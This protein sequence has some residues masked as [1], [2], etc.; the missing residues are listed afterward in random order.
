M[1]IQ[2]YNCGLTNLCGFHSMWQRHAGPRS[3]TESARKENRTGYFFSFTHLCLNQN[4]GR[5]VDDNFSIKS[6][7]LQTMQCVNDHIPDEIARFFHIVPWRCHQMETFS[8]LLAFVWGIHRSPVNS[9]HKGQWRGALMF[10]LICVWINGWVHNAEAGDL[11]H[12]RT[13]YDVLWCANLIGLIVI[14]HV[15]LGPWIT[16]IDDDIVLWRIYVSRWQCHKS[17]TPPSPGRRKQY[18]EDGR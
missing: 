3:M 17:V 13:H 9:P 5:P 12:S 14:S 10:S 2:A 6:R 7:T 4:G 11:R 8:A 1:V 16:C 18:P 15:H